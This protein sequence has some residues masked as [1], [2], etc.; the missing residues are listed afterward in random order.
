MGAADELVEVIDRDGAVVD[1]VARAVMRERRLAHRTVFIAVVDRQDRIV[2]HQRASW[3]DVWP[4]RWD[5]CFGGVV[6]VGERWR[7]A[8]ARELTEE[9]GVAVDP[10]DLRYL[11]HD[12]FESAD[13]VELGYVVLA[14]HDGPFR[15]DDGEVEAI[16][17]VPLTELGLWL[18]EHDVVDD[19][20]ALVV[21]SILADQRGGGW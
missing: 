12:W 2:V 1:V 10:A 14:R 20:R 6:G 17:R 9:A 4:G 11:W 18:T 3:K 5:V 16:D 21:P 8:A 19:S 15:P 13:V 7:D